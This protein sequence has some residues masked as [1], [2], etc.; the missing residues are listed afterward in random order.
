MTLRL[1]FMGTPA[2]ALPTLDRLQIAGHS[3]AAVYSQ[4]P[5][6]AGRGQRTRPSALHEAAE[7]RGIP[8]RTPAGLKA[9]DEQAA[10]KALAADA[11]VVVAYGLLLPPAILA[12]TRLGCYNLHPS[13]LP[14]W[15]GA[16]PVERAIEAGD[17]E[18]GICI[19]RM[20]AGLD[21]GPVVLSERLEIGPREA[22]ADLAAR[23]AERGAD[24]MVEALAG[25]AAGTLAPKP[26]PVT[27]ATY[28]AKI[29]PDE[30]RIDWRRPAAAID[31][32]IRAFNPSP[33]VWC[34]HG[35]ERIK[36]RAATP[37]EMSGT[38]GEVLDEQAT[39]ACGEG[40]LRLEVV[41]RPDRAPQPA[42]AF[43]RGYPLP[44]GAHLD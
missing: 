13:F 7:A 1:V 37:M 31:R 2:F 19:M 5:R 17:G 15:R 35:A 22:A 26:Q 29:M 23:L 24:M 41:Q 18:T 11:A 33:G 44:R 28:A 16:A 9:A 6:R 4:P 21:T 40:A 20:D 42:A 43:L 32:Q 39:V 3:I 14:R 8:V 34:M 10:F 36:V 30:G 38:P 12:A 27:G 25:I